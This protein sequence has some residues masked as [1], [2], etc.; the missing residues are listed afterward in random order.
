M[1]RHL[2][3]VAFDL[4]GLMINSEDM[5]RETGARILR[6]RGK[7]PEEALF[8]AMMGRTNDEALQVMV[9]WHE[10]DTT[11]A[12]LFAESTALMQTLMDERLAPM[13]GLF[14]LLDALTAATIPVAVTTSATRPYLE[15]VLD[16]LSLTGRFEFT[17]TGEDVRR[18]K[19]HPE[20]YQIASGRFG[21]ESRRMMVLEDSANG[22]KAA[23]AAGA[24]VVAVPTPYTGALDVQV[25]LVASSLG[26]RRIYEMLR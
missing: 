24:C 5:Y 7:E 22:C 2:D 19:P 18:G 25:D 23:V 14:E 9:D 13:P 6:R 4:D 17:L 15:D 10:L 20:M 12:E 26:D 11:V 21:V 3:A 16:R 1:P 8:Q